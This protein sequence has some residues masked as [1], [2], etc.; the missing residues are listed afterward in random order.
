VQLSRYIGLTTVRQH[1]E[2]SGYLG[3]QLLLEMMTT[4]DNI[5]PRRLPPLDLVMRGTTQHC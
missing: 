2:E 4:P 5:V 3:M 1:L